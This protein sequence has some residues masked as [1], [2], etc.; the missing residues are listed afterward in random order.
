MIGYGLT[1]TAA[2]MA[3]HYAKFRFWGFLGG[4]IAV[5]MAL[6]CL[7]DAAGKLYFGLA[8]EVG[9]FELPHWIHEAF[10]KYQ[11]GLPIYANLILVAM[12][13]VFLVAL[14]V[15]RNRGPVVILLALFT[16]M[17]VYSGMTHWYKSEQRNHWFGYWFG[18][19]MFTPPFTDPKTGKLSYD[20]DLRAQLLKDPEQAKI[21]YPEMCIRDRGNGTSKRSRL[22]N[23]PRNCR[24]VMSLVP[25]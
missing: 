7:K 22:R 14:A 16:L 23:A 25:G 24:N 1:L 3:T 12:P 13:I 9:L 5:I 4:G 8:G 10:T 6:F 19:D 17:P 11:Y 15:Y 21:I 2:Y 18:H 20:N